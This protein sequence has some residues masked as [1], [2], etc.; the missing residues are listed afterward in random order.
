MF[1]RKLRIT[2]TFALF[3]S[4][5]IH[6]SLYCLFSTGES[7]SFNKDTPIPIEIVYPEIKKEQ[8]PICEEKPAVKKNSHIPLKKQHILAPVPRL[9]AKKDNMPEALPKVNPLYVEKSADTNESE[10]VL[11]PVSQG[12]PTIPGAFPPAVDQPMG[13]NIA[14][15][16]GSGNENLL[17]SGNS[18]N[19]SAAIAIIKEAFPLYKTN[20]PPV[21]PPVARKRGYKGVVVLSVFVDENGRVKSLRV[22][23]SSGYSILDDAA[24]DSVKKWIFKPGMKGEKKAAMWVRVPIRFELN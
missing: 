22:F 11:V 10:P 1:S 6:G 13:S 19:N 3:L 21:Y 4:I 7:C 9:I 16:Y 18:G 23:N 17:T 8:T 15:G 2:P 5:G 14:S 20:P 24:L 12:K